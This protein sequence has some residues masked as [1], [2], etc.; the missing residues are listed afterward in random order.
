MWATLMNI[1]TFRALNAAAFF[2]A[3]SF[4]TAVSRSDGAATT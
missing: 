3:V 1:D 4:L 2:C